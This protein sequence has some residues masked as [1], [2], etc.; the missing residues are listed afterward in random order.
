[1]TR[2][3]ADPISVLLKPLLARHK[4]GVENMEKKQRSKGLTGN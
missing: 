4:E 2:Q 3:C 1:M